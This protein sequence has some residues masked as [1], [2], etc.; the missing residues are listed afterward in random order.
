MDVLK[1]FNMTDC[2]PSITPLEVVLKLD[3]TSND[4]EPVDP[5]LFKQ[6]IGSLRYLC[7]DRLDINF[8]VGLVSKFVVERRKSNFMAAK[9]ILRCLKGTM[10]CCS[11][12]NQ[13]REKLN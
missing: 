5:T 2:N 4:D 11:Y 12:V 9:R 8:A 10:K 6:L 3:N 13:I 7:N 1:R